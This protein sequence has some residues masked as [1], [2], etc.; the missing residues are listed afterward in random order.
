MYLIYWFW[1]NKKSLKTLAYPLSV[2]FLIGRW[3]I[4][5]CTYF[6]YNLQS[7]EL[8]QSKSTWMFVIHIESSVNSTY[9][10]DGTSNFYELYNYKNDNGYRILTI[11]KWCA[12][13]VVIITMDWGEGV[14][15]LAGPTLF[16]C[17]SIKQFFPF[18]RCYG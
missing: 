11:R 8:P 13:A 17:Q 6:W 14:R 1:I 2:G 7:L 10:F 15:F 16:P 5:K 9:T 3:K 4:N 12:F 18:P